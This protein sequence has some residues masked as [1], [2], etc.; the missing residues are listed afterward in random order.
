MVGRKLIN[1]YQFKEEVLRALRNNTSL[2]CLHIAGMLEKRE[3]K[4]RKRKL[5]IIKKI[6]NNKKK[7][8]IKKKKE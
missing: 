7:I 4:E 1:E 8:K 5:K 3:R 6:K 2:T